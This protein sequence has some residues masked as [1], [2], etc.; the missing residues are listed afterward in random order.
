MN[1]RMRM[2][3]RELTSWAQSSSGYSSNSPGLKT[4][5]ENAHIKILISNYL[6]Q[7]LASLN[8]ATEKPSTYPNSASTKKTTVEKQKKAIGIW[9]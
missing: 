7:E 1:E 4:K 5:M 2:P 6:L 9:S 8:S 3:D